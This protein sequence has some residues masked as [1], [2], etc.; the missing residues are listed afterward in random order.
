M[1]FRLLI[2][3]TQVNRN[4]YHKLSYSREFATG[5]TIMTF[6]S[7]YIIFTFDN[8]KDTSPYMKKYHTMYKIEH[9]SYGQYNNID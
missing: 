6:P 5:E 2:T 8:L 3:P 4:L 1:N 7:G 9:S